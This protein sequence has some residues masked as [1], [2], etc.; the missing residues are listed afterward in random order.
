MGEIVELMP[1]ASDRTDCARRLQDRVL[2]CARFNRGTLAAHE[3]HATGTTG[4][5]LAVKPD[6]R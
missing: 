6:S 5:L 3:L 4:A 1:P 2:E